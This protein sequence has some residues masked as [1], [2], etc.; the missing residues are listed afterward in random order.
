MID[1]S[2]WTMTGTAWVKAQGI[3]MSVVWAY[4]PQNA[5]SL[6]ETL[7]CGAQFSWGVLPAAGRRASGETVF[8]W[9]G[10]MGR[11]FRSRTIPGK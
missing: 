4:R 7:A 6:G 3:T 11:F 10:G 1:I 2:E 8:N 5:S 9:L